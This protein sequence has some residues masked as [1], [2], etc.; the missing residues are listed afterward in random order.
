MTIPFNPRMKPRLGTPINKAI[1]H[2]LGLVGCWL[3]NEGGS[4]QV[5][6]LS[7]NGNTGTLQADTYVVPGKFGSALSFDGDGDYIEVDSLPRIDFS[8]TISAL[9]KSPSWI[10]D[11]IIMA[12]GAYNHNRFFVTSASLNYNV[13][14]GATSW[15]KS[16]AYSFGTNQWYHV[17]ISIDY[18]TESAI[19]YVNG[20]EIGSEINKTVWP[21]PS[22]SGC[23]KWIGAASTRDPFYDFNGQIDHVMISNRALSANEIQQLYREPFFMFQ[24]ELIELWAASGGAPPAGHPYYYREFANRRIA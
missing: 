18:D 21:N 14:N 6:D 10:D 16:K 20:K 1:A 8:M 23:I 13:Y 3:F 7:G 19:W 11:N 2:K 17:A 12:G 4:G 5:F 22:S 24:R 9:I 15:Y